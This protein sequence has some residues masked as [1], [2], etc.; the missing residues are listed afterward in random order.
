MLDITPLLFIKK[1]IEAKAIGR[2]IGL[3]YTMDNFI[4]YI[5]SISSQIQGRCLTDEQ[6]DFVKGTLP[7]NEQKEFF[8]LKIITTKKDN[9]ESIQYLITD[10]VIINQLENQEVSNHIDLSKYDVDTAT[11]DYGDQIQRYTKYMLSGLRKIILDSHYTLETTCKLIAQFI[12]SI[13]NQEEETYFST[14]DNLLFKEIHF[15]KYAKE[16]KKASNA[17]EIVSYKEVVDKIVGKEKYFGDSK[18]PYIRVVDNKEI[19]ITSSVE[20]LN[21][22]DL[23]TKNIFLNLIN[24]NISELVKKYNKN[25]N[26]SIDT[27]TYDDD[28]LDNY[29]DYNNTLNADNFIKII[30][31]HAAKHLYFTFDF[32]SL[33]NVKMLALKHKGDG[34]RVVKVYTDAVEIEQYS[35]QQQPDIKPEKLISQIIAHISIL[36]SPFASLRSH[37]LLKDDSSQQKLSPIKKIFNAFCELLKADYNSPDVLG[38]QWFTKLEKQFDKE[39][40]DNLNKSDLLGNDVSYNLDF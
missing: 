17:Y 32:R 6:Y 14:K 33:G 22:I 10:K 35:I 12:L 28:H 25:Y 27:F 31:H 5:L 9:S 7:D 3:S 16:A 4:K 21:I 29:D 34:T 15:Y 39:V 13:F 40:I 26:F 24:D 38:T 20:A 19:I 37:I 18:S 30:Y 8:D 11:T 23:L 1:A 2:L 36:L